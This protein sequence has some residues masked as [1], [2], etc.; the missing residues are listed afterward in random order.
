MRSVP[1]VSTRP[2]RR[3][4]T[5][6]AD[7]GDAVAREG[8]GP[9][10]SQG[11]PLATMQE[12]ARYWATDYDWRKAE[13]KLNAFP[14]FVT[15][16]RRPGHPF[17]PRPLEARSALPLI[18]SARLARL[19]DRADQDHR[20][21]DRSHEVRRQGRGR[22]RRRHPVDA[23]LRLLG[24]AHEH[25]LGRR[26]HGPRLG[27]ADDAARAIPAT[28]PRAATG[29][30]SS[31]TRW[32]AGPPGLLAIHTNMPATVP[33]TSTWRL[34][35]GEPGARRPLGRGEARVRAVGQTLKQ[36]ATPGSWPP[37]P[38]T[39]YGIAD[40]PVGLAA[41]LLDHDDVEASRPRPWWRRSTGRAA[42]RAS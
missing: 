24:E 25:R 30:R 11:V 36:A 15:D 38:Q 29:G 34:L 12:L 22:V 21:A 37:R 5:P 41:W 17:H 2:M 6:P 40:S 3:W 31:S 8:D 10:L 9:D 39:L 7:R 19:G 42:P 14:Q 13:A 27:R 18:V 33:R 26:A 35:A 32:G 23:R 1:F 4:R 28:S 16:D 20:A